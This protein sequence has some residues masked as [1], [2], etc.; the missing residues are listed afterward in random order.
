MGGKRNFFTKDYERYRWAKLVA[1]GVSGQDMLNTYSEALTKMVENEAC[2]S[3][4][5]PS[6][7]TPT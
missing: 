1:P 5:A 6:S 4:S 3:S 2:R 7:A